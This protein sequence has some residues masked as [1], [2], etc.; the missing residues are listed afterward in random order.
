MTARKRWQIAAAVAVVAALIGGV[1]ALDRLTADGPRYS[2]DR[3][4]AEPGT[5]EAVLAGLEDRT[6]V[7]FTITTAHQWRPSVWTQGLD[8]DPRD[9]QRLLV[10]SGAGETGEQASRTRLQDLVTGEVFAEH[11]S[12]CEYR[13]ATRC[14][15]AEG[16]GFSPDRS[17]ILGLTWTEGL[18]HRRS[19]DNLESL[20]SV[21]LPAGTQGWGLCW[22]SPTQVI[23]SDGSAAL[24]RRDATT[25]APVA[26]GRMVTAHL[27]DAQVNGL[28]ELACGRYR[29][30]EGVWANVY[31]TDRLVFVAL[32]TGEVLAQIDLS[33]LRADQFD[34]EGSPDVANG[35]AVV[36]G[37]DD[38]RLYVTGKRWDRLYEIELVD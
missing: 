1:V 19:G 29:G 37:S 6:L 16:A 35:V 24:I 10:V 4:E 18:V 26:V 27:G 33:S 20:G 12:P 3:H 23:T 38:R 11:T 8:V 22:I 15:F 25:L 21:E 17:Q 36:P 14:E 5:P 2:M 7:E 9:P 28:N 31:P 34:R 30:V 32:S 13:G